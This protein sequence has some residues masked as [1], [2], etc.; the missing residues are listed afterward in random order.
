MFRKWCPMII[1]CGLVVSACS[2]TQPDEAGTSESEGTSM[3]QPLNSDGWS[4]NVQA[5]DSNQSD[6]GSTAG[7]STGT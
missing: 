5:T 4:S 1:I 3:E 2:A 6:A 7:T